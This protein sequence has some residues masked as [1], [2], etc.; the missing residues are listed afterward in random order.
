MN[1]H[2]FFLVLLCAVSLALIAASPA[3]TTILGEH[4][5]KA[6]ETLYCIG[7]GY[8]VRPAAIAEANGLSPT[9]RLTVGRC[10]KYRLCSG[11]AS[12]S[13]RCARRSSHP[14]WPA[15]H[16]QHQRRSPRLPPR[17]HHPRSSTHQ[18]AVQEQPTP[19][20]AATPFGESQC[21]LEQA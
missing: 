3:D 15:S 7:R 21:G 8:G 17:S 13:A 9:A 6:G 16:R 11:P 2:R 1:L 5:V 19:S 14:R 4:Q 20:S 18:P 12:R 10:S